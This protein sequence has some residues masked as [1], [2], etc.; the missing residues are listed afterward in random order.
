MDEKIRLL[1]TDVNRNFHK[2]NFVQK[3]KFSDGAKTWYFICEG[4]KVFADAYST[5]KFHF[6]L[7]IF[8][9]IPFNFEAIKVQDGRI[10]TDPN[11]PHICVD[12]NPGGD[13][14]T[15]NKRTI[16]VEF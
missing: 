16:K 3:H 10:M 2:F 7:K 11:V 12:N 9:E 13:Q 1:Y 15:I 5:I 6:V 8:L 14:S 4:C